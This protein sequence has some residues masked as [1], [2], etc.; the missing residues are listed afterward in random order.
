MKFWWKAQAVGIE[1]KKT[2]FFFTSVADKIVRAQCSVVYANDRKLW[3]KV[4]GFSLG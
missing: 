4:L 1:I 2:K 3:R